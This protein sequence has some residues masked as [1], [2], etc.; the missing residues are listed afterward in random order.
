MRCLKHVF[1]RGALAVG[2]L[3]SGGGTALLVPPAAEQARCDAVAPTAWTAP[4]SPQ[5]QRARDARTTTI[6]IAVARTQ[7]GGG[8]C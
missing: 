2:L 8:R 5:P 6:A 4:S 3:A 7:G 1:V